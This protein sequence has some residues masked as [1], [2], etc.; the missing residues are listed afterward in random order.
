MTDPGS[1]TWP[2]RLL[3]SPDG[4]AAGPT[5]REAR[6]RARPMVLGLDAGVEQSE[7]VGALGSRLARLHG[8]GLPVLPGFVVSTDA[9]KAWRDAG[10]AMPELVR[11]E[12]GVHLRALA[13]GLPDAFGQDPDAPVQL[14][15]RASRA[16]AMAR[17]DHREAAVPPLRRAAGHGAELE[18]ETA[19]LVEALWREHAPGGPLAVVVQAGTPRQPPERSGQ[20]VAITRDP[21]SGSPGTVGWFRT[22]DADA[23]HTDSLTVLRQRFPLAFAKLDGAMPLVESVWGDMCEVPF[24]IGR[25]RLWIL[26]TRPAERSGAAAIR[27]AVELVDEGLIDLDAALR[28][29]PLSAARE[30]QWPVFSNDQAIEVLARGLPLVA[31]AASGAAV[32]D[33]EAAAAFAARGEAT[34]LVVPDVQMV[35]VARLDGVGAVV[36]AAGKARAGAG[37][38]LRPARRPAVGDVA[39]LQVDLD[40]RVM[41]LAHGAPVH[42]GDRISVDGSRGVLARGDVRVLPPQPDVHVARFLTWC[43]EHTRIPVLEAAPRGWPRIAGLEQAAALQGTRAVIVA[44]EQGAD[45]ALAEL[46]AAAQAGG[47]TDLALELPGDLTDL[48]PPRAPWRSIVARREHAWAGQLLSSRIDVR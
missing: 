22:A 18:A 8:L 23:G 13:T 1:R 29:V 46:V 7:R 44:P 47:A 40:E 6:T 25:D 30:V 36:V 26:D 35:D 45:V 43:E 12:L 9:W 32:F 5:L 14:R 37:S 11:R 38:L 41:R 48:R 16:V 31:G 27:V 3:A 2:L 39:G 21:G 4:V 34:V 15:L 17:R 19:E 42:E 20:G 24:S 33:V 28:R 10:G